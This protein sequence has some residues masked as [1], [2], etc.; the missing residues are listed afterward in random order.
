MLAGKDLRSAQLV[1][2][3]GTSQSLRIMAP[4]KRGRRAF[5][6]RVERNVARTA[7]V[8]GAPGMTTLFLAHRRKSQARRF[9]RFEIRQQGQAKA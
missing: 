3:F 7:G 2:L 5:K 8:S 4:S 6:D 9:S 1:M